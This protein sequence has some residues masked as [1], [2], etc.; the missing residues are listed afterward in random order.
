MLKLWL[1]ISIVLLAGGLT[2]FVQGA[3]AIP[4]PCKLV[5]KAEMEQIVGPTSGAP[6]I[7]D[8]NTCEFTPAKTIRWIN[9]SLHDGELSSWKSRNGG[10][11]PLSV[12]EFGKDAFLVLDADGTTELFTKKGIFVLRVGMPKGPT[13]VE[14]VKAITRKALARL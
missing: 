10:K 6:T 2:G 8:G 11:S 9:V 5:S 3:S 12:P 4:D 7:F 13:A 1:G 14:M